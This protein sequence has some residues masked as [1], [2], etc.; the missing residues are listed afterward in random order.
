M[1]SKIPKNVATDSQARMRQPQHITEGI[2]EE[3][4][5]QQERR[6]RPGLETKMCIAMRTVRGEKETGKMRPQI[7]D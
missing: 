1:P 5:E 2:H 3:E 7:A 6:G 4:D